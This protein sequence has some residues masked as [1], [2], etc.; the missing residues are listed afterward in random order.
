MALPFDTDRA[1]PH[2]VVV[3][4][5]PVISLSHSLDAAHTLDEHLQDNPRDQGQ[6]QR[7]LPMDPFLVKVFKC[8]SILA[9][10]RMLSKPGT[11]PVHY[12]RIDLDRPGST[13]IDLHHPDRQAKRSWYLVGLAEGTPALR[14]T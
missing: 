13:W 12:L 14:E 9:R 6:V 7:H 4:T 10:N 5:P 2:N 3:C 11:K 1:N 8:F